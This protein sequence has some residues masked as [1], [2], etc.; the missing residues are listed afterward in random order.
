MYGY[1]RIINAPP[2]IT[3]QAGFEGRSIKNSGADSL[4]ARVGAGV[5]EGQDLTDPITNAGCCLQ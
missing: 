2:L 1:S 4:G 5:T 3:G